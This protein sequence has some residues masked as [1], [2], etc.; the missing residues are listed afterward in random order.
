MMSQ[1]DA[2]H[3]AVLSTLGI[4]EGKVELTKEQRS[5]VHEAVFLMFQSGETGFR[6]TE[7]NKAKLADADALRSYI[8]GLV[9]NHLRKDKR[10]NG[11]VAYQPKNPGSRPSD[12]T[13]KELRKLLSNYEAGSSEANL[14]QEAIDKRTAEIQATKATTKSVDYSSIPEDLKASLGIN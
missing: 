1:A 13:L 14:V 7:S 2:V 3:S 4:I 11:N 6:E 12:P 10:L 5:Q 8:T 9:S